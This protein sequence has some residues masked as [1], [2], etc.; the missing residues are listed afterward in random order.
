VVSIVP[1]FASSMLLSNS[2]HAKRALPTIHRASDVFNN[3]FAAFVTEA[4]KHFGVP[5]HWIRAVL[6]VESGRK[7][8][9]RSQKGAP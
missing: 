1:I 5:E 3:P 7:L 8:R 2:A 4:S 6:Q 9:A